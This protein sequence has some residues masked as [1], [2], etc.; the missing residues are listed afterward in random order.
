MGE[1]FKKNV[2]LRATKILFEFLYCTCSTLWGESLG[3]LGVV[4]REQEMREVKD[5][6]LSYHLTQHQHIFPG[7]NRKVFVL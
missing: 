7:W 4:L 2:K 6:F 5:C 1:R 3:A